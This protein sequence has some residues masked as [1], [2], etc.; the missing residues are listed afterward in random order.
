MYKAQ[1]VRWNWQK[2]T[3]AKRQKRHGPVYTSIAVKGK[4]GVRRLYPGDCETNYGRPQ[5]LNVSESQPLFTAMVS[6]RNLI[7][8]WPETDPRWHTATR[9]TKMG[10]YNPTM[11]SHFLGALL[12]FQQ[13][14]FRQGGR[15]LR[16][17]FLELE[18]VLAD[19]HIASV[20]DCCIAAPQLA[21]NHNRPDIL[22][23]F[24]RYLSALSARKTPGHPLAHA[25]KSLTLLFE[26]TPNITAISS[27]TTL[28]WRLWTDT[29]SSLLGEDSISTLHTHRA[30]LI[31]H[32]SPPPS[33]T[34][35]L[36]QKYSSLALKASSTL[37]ESHTSTL[38]IEYDAL[39]TQSR[40][41]N[42]VP[43]SNLT[44]TLN[45]ESQTFYTRLSS[46]LA[47]LTTKY[48]HS[49]PPFHWPLESRQIYRGCY[50]LGA[51]RAIEA[52]D[53]QTAAEFRHSFLAAPSDGEWVQ[54]ALRMEDLLRGMGRVSE[55]EEVKRR[56]GE[57]VR[58]PK[59]VVEVEGEGGGV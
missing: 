33:L 41:R 38:A 56:R 45:K 58:L 18:D 20:W 35:S 39:L 53:M 59:E 17:A 29:L 13:G 55:A 7:L 49:Q 28:A 6:F 9:F 10:H 23:T 21:L 22:L 15:L 43:N 12:Q 54:Y 31:I 57:V 26:S 44:T 30:Y 50:F 5:I 51:T 24:L 19:G 16:A 46:I 34:A 40:F 2:Y 52:G 48:S 47:R 1:F 3:T 11:I 25:S 14:E 37:G 27:Y 42:S 8:G 36:L 32:P 4:K